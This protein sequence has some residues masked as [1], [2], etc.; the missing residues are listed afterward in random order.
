M[1]PLS[2]HSSTS[3]PSS[4]PLSSES[5]AAMLL[6]ECFQFAGVP[7]CSGTRDPE[8][9]QPAPH[10]PRINPC[11]QVSVEKVRRENARWRV[12][13]ASQTQQRESEE[14]ETGM[15]AYAWPN[16]PSS[17]GQEHFAL[18]A[19]A[20]I[21]FG[22][23]SCPPAGPAGLL[24]SRST[25]WSMLGFSDASNAPLQPL[26]SLVDS[27]SSH[28]MSTVLQQ[29]QFDRTT[30]LERCI[31]QLERL[32]LPQLDQRNAELEQRLGVVNAEVTCLAQRN[33]ELERKISS[34]D[35]SLQELEQL[36]TQLKGTLDAPTCQ[37]DRIHDAGL[38]SSCEAPSFKCCAQ[39]LNFLTETEDACH[40]KF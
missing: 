3:P 19:D 33:A 11:V 36:V 35:G 4:E 31:E 32:E 8:E 1:S 17:M 12:F 37:Q 23:F 27:E 16:T 29:Q 24:P 6:K 7:F 20:C 15:A 5:S 2:E 30:N 34:Q 39:S 14:S 26:E 22:N 25:A 28:S 21:E 38:L 9:S 13:S 18:E 40:F 10:W